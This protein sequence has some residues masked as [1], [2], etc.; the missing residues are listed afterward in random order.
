[1][2]EQILMDP[3]LTANKFRGW[4]EANLALVHEICSRQGQQ[5]AAEAKAAAAAVALS[6]APVVE[7]SL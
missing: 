7:T 5:E 2:I 6:A 1:M 3:E 4:K